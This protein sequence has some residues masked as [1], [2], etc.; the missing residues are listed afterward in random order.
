MPPATPADFEVS[1]IK[2]S[3]PD[4][5]SDGDLSD[6][7]QIKLQGMTLDSLI[8]IAW[9]L[10]QNGPMLQG[11]PKWLTEDKFDILAKAPRE[12]GAPELDEDDLL[13]M[14]RK[15]SPNDS[16]SSPTPKISR[17]TPTTSSR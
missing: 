10:P 2:P 3:K 13:P 6:C 12:A 7:A 11:A 4:A 8:R 16:S 17:S 9:D 14:L 15:L 5:Q 1:V